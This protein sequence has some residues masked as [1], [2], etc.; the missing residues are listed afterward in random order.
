MTAMHPAGPSRRALLKGG[1]TS[2]SARE[3]ALHV[4]SGVVTVLPN[5]RE[6]ILDRLSALAGVE[7]HHAESFKIVVV[8]EAKDSGTVGSWLAEIATWTGVLSANMVFEQTVPLSEIGE[9]T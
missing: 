8:M 2:A 6:E 4:S 1:L 5:R 3:D 7:I 9:A